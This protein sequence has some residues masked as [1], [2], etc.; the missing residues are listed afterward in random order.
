[1]T[2]LYMTLLSSMLMLAASLDRSYHHRMI[3][4][5]FACAVFRAPGQEALR[6]KGMSPNR[7]SQ[8]VLKT[9]MHPQEQQLLAAKML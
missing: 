2:I 5:D 3:I 8:Q 7:A 1:M 6:V 4:C 9:S